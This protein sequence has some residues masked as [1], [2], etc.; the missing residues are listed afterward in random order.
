VND[1]WYFDTLRSLHYEN[2]TL[3][4][5]SEYNGTI[6]RFVWEGIRPDMVAH[7]IN[8]IPGTGPLLAVVGYRLELTAHGEPTVTSEV[9]S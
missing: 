5:V 9:P 8:G 7:G 3:T 2:G 1:I 4:V 6:Q